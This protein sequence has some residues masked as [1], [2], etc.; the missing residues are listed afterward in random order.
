VVAEVVRSPSGKP[1]YPHARS[2]AEAD[3]EA[4][5]PAPVGGG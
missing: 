1:D 5:A 4:A 2:L 3:A